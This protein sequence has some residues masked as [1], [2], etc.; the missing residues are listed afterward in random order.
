MKIAQIVI[1]QI[2]QNTGRRPIVCRIDTDCGIYGYGEASVSNGYSSC[3]AVKMLEEFSS[4]LIGKDPLQSEKIFHELLWDGYWGQAGG[5]SY[6]AAMSALDIAMMDIKGKAYGVPVYMLLGGKFRSSLKC[7]A[8]Q[9]QIGWGEGSRKCLSAEDYGM[10]C[11]A[12]AA[13]GFDAVKIDLG[14][15]DEK[16]KLIP[17]EKKTGFLDDEFCSLFEKR[18]SMIRSMVGPHVKIYLDGHGDYDL[19]AA[20]KLAQ[21][22]DHYQVGFFEEAT[23]A[24]SSSMMKELEKQASIPLAAGERIFTR[25][26]FYEYLKNHTIQLAQPDVG[27]CGGLEECRK[28]SNLAEIFDVKIQTHISGTPIIQAASVQLEMAI[29]NFF[30]HEY[31]C[32]RKTAQNYSLGKHVYQPVHG[33]LS[34]WDLPGIGQELSDSGIENSKITTIR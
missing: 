34:G 10:A 19:P 15:F 33:M 23:S 29:P 2:R 7:Y 12:A 30:S 16:G 20:L 11:A 17:R 14:R 4:K 27:N 9:V 26:G 18:L 24:L 13:E 32:E 5:V 22:A 31:H 1:F 28:I 25:W 8:S 6:Y 3:A 21:I